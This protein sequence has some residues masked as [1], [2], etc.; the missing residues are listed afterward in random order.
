MYRRFCLLVCAFLA[1]TSPSYGQSSDAPRTGPISGYMEMHLNRPEGGPAILDFHRFVLLFSHRFSDRIRFVGELELEHAFVEGLEEAGELE[2]EQAYLDFLISR[3]MQ[4]P[5]RHGAGA[6]GH[7]QRAARAAGL[8]RRRA[9]L[10]GHRDRAVDLVRSRRRRPRRD[11][12][13]AA[14]S[15]LRAGAA[16]RARVLRRRRTPRTAG[17]KGRKRTS[18][19]P[20]SRAG[21]STSACRGLQLGVSGWHGDSSFAVPRLDTKVWVAEADARYRAGADRASRPVRAR[22]HRR[23]RTAERGHRTHHRR[24]AEC[25][26]RAAR[27]LCRGRVPG[28]GSR[29]RRATWRSSPATR[30][31]TRSSA[32]RP[33]SSRSKSSIGRPGSSAR[34]TIPTPTSPSRST[35]RR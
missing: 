12:G 32:C 29:A 19:T 3:S 7:H 6:D 35:T 34:P 14:L 2:L 17:R 8:P 4:L 10:R 16:Q 25:R 26:E 13:R 33:A 21:W 27:V 30:T 18:A 11:W 24:V 15:R 31:S 9:A 22:R 23:C 20:R 5:R 1:T 28:V